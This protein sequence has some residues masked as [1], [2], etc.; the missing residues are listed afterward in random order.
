MIKKISEIYQYQ[1]D[2]FLYPSPPLTFNSFG[3]IYQTFVFQFK[4]HMFVFIPTICLDTRVRF[5]FPKIYANN[6]Y[7]SALLFCIAWSPTA[8][9]FAECQ[10]VV[11]AAPFYAD[12]LYDMCAT[13]PTLTEELLCADI[14]AY[15]RECR[16]NL[17]VTGT[18]WRT[19]D[20]CRK[21]TL[22]I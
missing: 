6:N 1:K 15:A 19:D 3:N 10:G 5:C 9:E 2:I 12:C 8:D 14:N 16:A 17:V 11:D 22:M 20:F 4:A 13:Y 7:T 21:Y 18:T